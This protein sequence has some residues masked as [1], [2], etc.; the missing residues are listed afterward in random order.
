[1]QRFSRI[2]SQSPRVGKRIS[3]R[4]VALLLKETSMMIRRLATGFILLMAMVLADVSVLCAEQQ[5]VASV[6]TGDL[7][8]YRSAHEAFMKIL[9]AGGMGEDKVKVYVQSPNPDAMSW[10]N[11]VRK[12]VGGGANLIITYGAPVTLVAKKEAKG[13]PLLFADVYDPVA[14]G[15]VKD[16]AV[17][18]GEISGIASTTPVETLARTL[19]DIQAPKTI[20]ALFSSSEQGS[21]LQEKRMEEQGKK[22]GFSVIKVDV[23]S[24]DAAK[25]SIRD[26][27]GKAEAVYVT[28]SVLLTQGLQDLITTATEHHLPILTQI[29]EAG[30]KGALLT[31]EADPIEQGQLLAVHA[32]QVLGG[33]KVFTLPVRTP[34]KIALVVNMKIAEELG[35]KIPFQALSLATRVIK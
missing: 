24:R 25:Q 32:L 4:S 17:T 27:S 16:L 1:M 13:I 31:L 11:S 2:G 6:I 26:A 8:R 19:V 28:E 20:L 22:L 23:K 10:A 7:P 3:L 15:I 18:G 33:Q 12:A 35:I 9:R 29:P 5:F 14:L 34:K 30:E 21:L